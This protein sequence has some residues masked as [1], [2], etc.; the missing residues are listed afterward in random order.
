MLM[1]ECLPVLLGSSFSTSGLLPAPF[2]LRAGVGSSKKQCLY[3]I[4]ETPF[5]E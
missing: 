1:L 5:F 3:N 4:A 2:G